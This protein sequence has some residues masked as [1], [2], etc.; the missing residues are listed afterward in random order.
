MP[1]AAEE[2]AYVLRTDLVTGF[3]LYEARKA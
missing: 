2:N 3:Y 1:L